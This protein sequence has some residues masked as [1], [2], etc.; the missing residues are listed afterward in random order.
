[1]PFSI[2]HIALFIL[3][4]FLSVCLF[5][6]PPTLYLIPCTLYLEPLSSFL[7]LS[8]LSY[9]LFLFCTLHFSIC[10]LQ[11]P[12][13]FNIIFS[14]TQQHFKIAYGNNSFIDKNYPL[15][16][17]I[18]IVTSGAYYDPQELFRGR[19]PQRN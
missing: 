13:L 12:F 3:H 19:G 17:I 10:I 15:S 8:A 1:M 11:S 7:L 2:L 5:L 9:E 18:I 14:Q 16:K 6:L 4:C